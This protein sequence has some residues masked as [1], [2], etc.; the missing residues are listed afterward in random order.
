MCPPP[1]HPPPPLINPQKKSSIFEIFAYPKNIDVYN[2]SP[3]L[4][5]ITECTYC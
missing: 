4:V 5:K 1:Q 2:I 3:E